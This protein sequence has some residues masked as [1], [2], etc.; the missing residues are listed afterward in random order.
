MHGVAEST[1]PCPKLDDSL[2]HRGLLFQLTEN[3]A[4]VSKKSVD[5]SKIPSAS[6][7]TRICR[8]KTIENLG[9]E[10]TGAVRHRA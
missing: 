4:G 1:I 7:G 10:N 3:P 6:N 8:V 5:E 9:R 2:V